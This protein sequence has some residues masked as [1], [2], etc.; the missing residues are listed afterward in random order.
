MSECL[1]FY[2]L[3]IL[4]AIVHLGKALYFCCEK[5]YL[6]KIIAVLPQKREKKIRLIQVW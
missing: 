4:A 1:I 6:F 5:L 2:L 3:P